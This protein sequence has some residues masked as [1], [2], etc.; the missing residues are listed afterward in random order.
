[1]EEKESPTEKSNPPIE[2]D[3]KKRIGEVLGVEISAPAGMKNPILV[4]I[5]LI[6]G[7]FLLLFI[8]SKAF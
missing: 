5:L 4:L 1:M 3:K 8:L 2:K 7:N 6:S